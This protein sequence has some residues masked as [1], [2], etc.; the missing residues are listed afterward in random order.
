M[1]TATEHGNKDCFCDGRNASAVR[2][3]LWPTR[4]GTGSTLPVLQDQPTKQNGP[5]GPLSEVKPVGWLMG[6]E[7]TTTGITIL[8]STN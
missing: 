1:K 4:N 2:A 5:E 6:L 8:D 3:A 7:P